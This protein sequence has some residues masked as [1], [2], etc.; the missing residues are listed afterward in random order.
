M[1][2]DCLEIF[3]DIYLKKGDKYIVDSYTLAEGSYV[4]VDEEGNI[5]EKFEL[6]KKNTDKTYEYY[7]YF[8]ERD[9]LSKLVDM[10]KPID[11][12]K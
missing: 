4:L 9:Y 11:S 2:K 8:A 7:N 10:N 5:K 1:L 6:D 3:K 12:K